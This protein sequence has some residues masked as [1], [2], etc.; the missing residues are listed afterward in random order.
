[1]HRENASICDV[2][3]WELPVGDWELFVATVVPTCAT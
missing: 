3:D 2:G 1:M